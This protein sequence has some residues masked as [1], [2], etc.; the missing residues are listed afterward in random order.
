MATKAY[1]YLRFSTT[2]Q[3]E[4]DSLRRQ[5]QAAETYAK[6]HG[7]DLDESLK[8]SD[9]G[10]SAYHGANVQTG[11]LSIFRRA[12]EDGIVEPGSYLLVESLD[13]ISRQY[14]LKA[15]GTLSDICE[16]GITV[17]TLSD[18]HIYTADKLQKDPQALL[19]S[20]L[21]FIRA[22]EESEMK[23]K[24]LK[25]AWKNK[26][27]QAKEKP[28]TAR[29]PHWLKL[30][31]DRTG[32]EIIDE[33]AQVVKDIFKLYLQGKGQVQIARELNQ[34]GIK[35]W[36]HSKTGNPMWQNSYISKILSFRA[37]I[38]EFTPHNLI[39]IDGKKKKAPLE[40]I[41]NYYPKVITKRTF[42]RVQALRMSK[43]S[44]TRGRQA[45]RK[46]S[47]VLSFL[48]KCPQC[49]STMTLT[50]KK[51]NERYLVCVKAKN[52]AGCKYKMVNYRRVQEA[53]FEQKER[54]LLDFPMDSPKRQRLAEEMEH[55][56]LE[57]SDL[58][59]QFNNLITPIREGRLR[60]TEQ[61]NSLLEEIEEKRVS[62]RDELEK[63]KAEHQATAKTVLDV[64]LKALGKALE[65]QD[66]AEIN[67]RF[68]ELF[69]RVIV[70][71]D[72]G[73]LFFDWKH[74]DTIESTTIG[75]DAPEEFKNRDR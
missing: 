47:N 5:T 2:A 1:S 65:G 70:D 45:S 34:K 52:G 63:K 33:R 19:M 3:Q 49:G 72:L 69:S 30:N 46:V 7:L 27:S 16:M 48:A 71:Y 29:A 35:P 44:Q 62:L 15:V 40:P 32:F 26:R 55:I 9:L 8:F 23:S 12:I 6:E 39:Y 10:V 14:P 21:I 60:N 37:T 58:H 43:E 67:T 68:R 25:A 17:I 28:L 4:G 36:G 22:N 53:I 50:S 42:D 20:I 41:P 64:Q 31:D 51:K 18:G 74:G 75:Y 66:I 24:R 56:E 73:D 13:R 38:G 54:L 59:D 61:I 11:A 57:L